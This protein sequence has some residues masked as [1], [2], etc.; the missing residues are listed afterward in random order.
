[1]RGVQW[2]IMTENEINRIKAGNIEWLAQ[3]KDLAV[4]G[5]PE[6][7][8]SACRE[9]FLESYHESRFSLAALFKAVEKA[10]GLVAGMGLNIYKHLL[11]WKKI[12]FNADEELFACLYRKPLDTERG[13]SA[14][15]ERQTQLMELLEREGPMNIG[16]I[17][18]LTELLVKEITP[19]LHR[20]Q[21][22]FLIYEDQNEGQDGRAWYRFG[23]M[24]P[25]VNLQKH[26]RIDALKV[27]LRRFA[28]RMV[29]LTRI[30]Q[31]PISNCPSRTSRR[32]LPSCCP[33]MF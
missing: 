11:Y 12:A 24:F 3:A 21:E 25:N 19:A 1:M 29:W 15:T 22:A 20:L 9:Y 28:Y 14:P 7:T 31:K 33:S 18:E 6:I 23:E 4:F 2:N 10:F 5:L 32:R 8:Q 30:W 27:L 17:K 16:L 13:R 26:S